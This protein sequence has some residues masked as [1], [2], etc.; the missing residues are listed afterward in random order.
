MNKVRKAVI[1]AAG[2]GKRLLPFTLVVP[3]E[4]IPIGREPILM[5][6]L[7]EIRE[8]GLDRVAIIVS[9]KDDLTERFLFGT[10][11]AA[12]LCESSV[13]ELK[14]ILSSLEVELIIQP[15]PRGLGDALGLARGF[16][17]DDPFAVLLPDN[18]FFGSPAP[19]SQIVPVHER[20]KTHVTGLIKTNSEEAITFGNCGAVNVEVIGDGEY[21]VLEIGDKG[22]GFFSQ[23][24][25]VEVYRWYARHIFPPSFFDYLDKYGVEKDNE[26]DD[27]PVLKALVMEEGIIGRLL[28]GKGF[29]VGNERGLMAAQKFLWEGVSKTWS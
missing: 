24:E 8:A 26:V 23:E 13:A 10:P 6:T 19:L 15:E 5:R 7:R 28:D 4:L 21:R 11:P 12:L 25:G 29:D 2:L 22:K 18:V 20:E 9:S 16:V 27:V 3:K 17:G 1:P 14:E